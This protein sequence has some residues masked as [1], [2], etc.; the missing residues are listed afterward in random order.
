MVAHTG[1][2]VIDDY[3][4]ISG[5]RAAVQATL[6]HLTTMPNVT[7][8]MPDFRYGNERDIHRVAVSPEYDRAVSISHLRET[9][10]FLFHLR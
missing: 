1:A 6:E 7:L 2:F 9:I 5:K 10:L 8:G 3:R 4:Q